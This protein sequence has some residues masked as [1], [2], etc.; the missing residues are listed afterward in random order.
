MPYVVA[1]E[2]KYTEVRIHPAN[3][4]VKTIKMWGRYDN[5]YL[6]G[7]KFYDANGKTVLKAGSCGNF[8]KMA[9][10]EF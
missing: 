8:D 7:L 1:P 6:W 2:A 4:E 3:A 5:H 9:C 10:R